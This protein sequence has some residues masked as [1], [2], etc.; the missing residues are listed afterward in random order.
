MKVVA[1]STSSTKKFSNEPIP[2]RPVQRISTLET[3]FVPAKRT[4]IRSYKLAREIF[5]SRKETTSQPVRT[6]KFTSLS[7]RSSTI[8]T[9]ETPINQKLHLSNSTCRRQLV[10]Q[11]KTPMAPLPR[12]TRK[13]KLFGTENETSLP[14]RTTRKVLRAPGQVMCWHRKAFASIRLLVSLL[15][16]QNPFA[17]ISTMAPRS[18]STHPVTAQFTHQ[19]WSRAYTVSKTAAC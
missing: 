14:S 4:R 13:A 10:Q 17:S 3:A 18:A 8:Y 5:T 16:T 15:H 9:S 6:A 1:S 19:I 2:E 11:L 7:A 12:L